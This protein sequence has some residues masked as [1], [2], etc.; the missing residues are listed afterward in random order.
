MKKI[1]IIDADLLG[2]DKHRFPNLACEKISG[3]YKEK[4][5]EVELLLEY[6]FKKMRKYEAVYIS[7][8]FTDTKCPDCL[9][10]ESW[11]KKHP[12]IHVGGTGFYFDKAP[13]LLYEIEHH[14]PDYHLYD[15][16]IEEEK[17]KA[18]VKAQN[19]FEKGIKKRK[20][21]G[22]ILTEE[23]QT[24]AFNEKKYLIQFKE[25][26][27]YSIGFV[28]RGCFRK[29]GFCVN[30]KYDSVF[31]HS[32]LTEFYDSS[33]KKICLL[34]DNF[35]GC[36]KWREILNE[37]IATGKQFKFKQ[38]LDER[39]LTE[40]KCKILFESK[41]D[42]DFTFAFDKI[43]DYDL[44]KSKLELIKKY[45]R[46]RSVKFYVLV[47]FESTDY[48]DIENAFKR[49]KLL[50]EY[51]CLPYIMRYQSENSQPWKESPLRSL[52]VAIAR[53]CNQPSIVKKMTF[54]EFC[55]RNQDYKKDKR[56]KCSTLQALDSFELAHPTIAKEYFD[57]RFNDNNK[58]NE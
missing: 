34:D 54:R 40:E 35:L 58:E 27:D 3:Y 13:N 4:G 1:G 33:R 10:K 20:E 22:E 44:I 48:I 47:G 31:V 43:Q 14:M 11:L 52:Y 30:K 50:L 7:K 36:G 5:Y 49:I 6:D 2:R 56:T 45:K 57:V 9:K 29:C 46:T 18:I 26:L 39:L 37:I 16:W 51:G 23:E 41:Y 25:Y 28:T 19:E 12:K 17:N 38:G 8:V 32:P 15:K 53:W 24:F 21:D 42:G 55:V